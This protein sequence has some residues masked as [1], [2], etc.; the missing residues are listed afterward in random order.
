MTGEGA[1]GNREVPHT[2]VKRVRGETLVSPRERAEGERSCRGRCCR[3]RRRAAAKTELNNQPNTNREQEHA[4]PDGAA[5]QEADDGHCNLQSDAGSRKPDT[6]PPRGDEHQRVAR[7]GA[8]RGADVER[9]PDAEAGER[10]ADQRD[11]DAERL[12]RESVDPVERRSGRSRTSRREPHSGASRSPIPARSRQTSTS[13]IKR[14]E[15]V[16]ALR[17][18]CRAA[19]RRPWWSTSQGGRPSSDSR[20]KTIPHEQRKSPVTSQAIREAKPP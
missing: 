5:E 15:Q 4:D 10:E 1:W 16:G 11:P 8:E 13:T 2:R 17:R 6:E 12:L 3:R 14:D 9:R 7:A 20:K 18:R 19:R